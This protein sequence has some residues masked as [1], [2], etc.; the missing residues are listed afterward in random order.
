MVPKKLTLWTVLGLGVLLSAGSA[1]AGHRRARVAQ[2]EEAAPSGA[3]DTS[4]GESPECKDAGVTLTFPVNSA[5]INGRGRSSL[6]GIAKWMSQG[7]GRSVQMEGYTD[8]TG[9]PAVNEELRGRRSQAA[10][11][12]LVARGVDESRI[13]IIETGGK[14]KRPDMKNARAVAVTTC[15]G[16]K[17]AVVTP[18]PPPPEQPAP[19]PQP[20]V[21]ET[22]PPP[23]PPVAQAQEPMPAP[24]PPDEGEVHYKDTPNSVIGIGATLGGGV[25]DFVND[26]AKAFANIGGSWEARLTFGTRMPVALEG[27]Y[28]GSAQGIQALGLETNAVLVGNGA[29]G[30]VRI[31]FTTMRIQP[32][33]FGGAGWINY[34]VRNTTITAADVQRSDNVLEVPFGVGLS[35]RIGK[36]LLIDVRGTG[37]V[38]YGD[39]LFNNLSATTNAGNPGLNSWNAGARLGWEF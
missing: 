21:V 11:D 19:P 30:D 32:Y 4:S 38:V 9:T 18:P 39:T 17:Q 20:E 16:E 6:N 27:A 28:I 33:I 8:S 1:N 36:G 34:Q 35:A 5:A 29:E 14:V 24:V 25:T 26:G 10:K 22:P 7:E 23:A 3:P 15:E 2:Q 37:R 12:Y 31:N 13:K